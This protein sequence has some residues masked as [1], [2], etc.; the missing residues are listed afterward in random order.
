MVLTISDDGRGVDVK[1]I[2][3]SLFISGKYTMDE[4]GQLSD[5][6]VSNM[7]LENG[8][9]ISEHAG[10]YSGRGVGMS[11]IK[12]VVENLGGNANV[13]SQSGIGVAYALRIPLEVKS[14]VKV[15]DVMTV[16][17]A[18]TLEAEKILTKNEKK[19]QISN[20]WDIRSGQCE[21]DMLLEVSAY[22]TIQGIR[23][24]HVCISA[25]EK[26]LK[27]LI[28]HYGLYGKY[29]G[30]SLRTMNE[31]LCLFAESTTEKTVNA[32]Q[33]ASQAIEI[34]SPSLISQKKFDELYLG[35][36]GA[37][38]KMDLGEG[39]LTLMVLSAKVRKG[40]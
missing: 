2:K 27:H 34:T 5:D 10:A 1:E 38:S 29:K 15:F 7:I 33:A 20:N 40:A 32:L 21:E 24:T 3:N 4:L 14:K 23:D 28:D 12:E 35:R 22:L 26:M 37:I 17:N 25:D 6:F 19:T 31:A 30:M 36:E 18:F 13:H 8:V 11:C 39:K 16:Q 9:S